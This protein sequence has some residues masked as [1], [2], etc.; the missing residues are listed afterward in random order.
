VAVERDALVLRVGADE[1]WIS[2][3]AACSGCGGC[4]GRCD[5][6][7]SE[8]SP[9]GLRLSRA[10]FTE[11]PIPGQRVRLR[12]EAPALLAT[13]QRAYGWPL[14]G[15]LLGAG[16]AAMLNSSLRLGDAGVLL[17]ALLGTLLGMTLSKRAL[18][19]MR[20]LRVLPASADVRLTDPPSFS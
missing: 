13:A 6:L 20:Q 12:W 8:L 9:A 16:L 7:Q 4:Q 3:L 2:P 10:L 1:A 15:L 5:W 14:L 11:A 18:A 17:G 19:A